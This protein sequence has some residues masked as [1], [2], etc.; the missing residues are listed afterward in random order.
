[1]KSKQL[2]IG[3]VGEKGSGKGTLAK[4]LQE[5]EPKF[6]S[7]R[8]SDILV[9]TLKLWSLPL[10][11]SNLQSLATVMDKEYG[12]GTLA[13]ALKQ[14]IQS[15]TGDMVIVD[16]IRRRPEAKLIRGFSNNLIVYI[17]ADARKRYQNLKNR[18]DKEKET[19]L[20]LKQFMNEE[21]DEA[22]ILIPEIGKTA[23]FKIIN[24]GL[25]EDFQ[26][27]VRDFFSTHIMPRLEAL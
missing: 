12:N 17:T 6:S 16:G 27:Q 22:E 10:T 1:M 7:I 5:I 2:I 19:G 24:E 4:F 14:R 18:S 20:S 11:R 9:E 8:F 3:L 21:K 23:D 26:K 15:L 25:I 13:N